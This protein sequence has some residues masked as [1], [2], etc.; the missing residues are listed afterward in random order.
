MTDRDRCPIDGCPWRYPEL[1]G[2][3]L[4]DDG[5]AT[6]E[7]FAS[8]GDA[9]LHFSTHT[10]DDWVNQIGKLRRQ[11]DQARSLRL[12]H[13]AGAVDPERH[14]PERVRAHLKRLGWVREG[15]GRVAELW[16]PVGAPGPRVTVPLIPTAP[17][18]AK[19]LGFLVSDL[20]GLYGPG[21][22]AVLADIAAAVDA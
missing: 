16:H 12:A 3:V 21:Q 13:P 1:P 7:F 17:G 11:L 15:G 14:T 5:Y 19:V 10:T 22:L 8:M 18:Y 20:A 2:P 9:R 4:G 6:D